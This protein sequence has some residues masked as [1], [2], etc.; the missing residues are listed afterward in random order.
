MVNY[1]IPYASDNKEDIKVGLGVDESMVA[2]YNATLAAT[3]QKYVLLPASS[4][5]LPSEI[6]ISKGTQLWKQ[7]LEINTSGL[8]PK[9]YYVLPVVITNTPKGYTI[10]GNFGHV[11]LRIQMN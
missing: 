10:S 4:Y 8:T 2:R 1:T 11:Y 5:T 9:T 6:T 3:A 7:E